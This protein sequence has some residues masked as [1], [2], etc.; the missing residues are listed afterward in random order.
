MPLKTIDTHVHVWDLSKADYPWL[1]GDTSLLNQTWEI[2]ALETERVAAGVTEGILVQAAGN[3]E[4]TDHMLHVA[5]NTSW[6]SGVVAWLPLLDPDAV[7]RQLEEKHLSNPYFCGVRHQ[8][9][10]EPNSEWLLQDKVIESLKILA[11][12]S[13]PFDIV[14]VKTA[15]IK[16][17]LE[18]VNRIPALNMVFDHLSQPPISSQQRFGEWGELM[19]TAAKHKA[20]SAKISGL[21]TASGHFEGRTRKEIQPYIE[22]AI[23]HFGVERCFCGGDWP[24]SL[25]AGEYSSIWKI[26]REVL[27]EILSTEEQEQVLYHSAKKFYTIKTPV[28]AGNT[29]K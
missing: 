18:V 28:K 22:F 17:A 10:D 21:G 5:A 4:D 8:I 6:I 27:E 23:K 19:R 25:L 7:Q 9:H 13:I 2:G 26:Y 3:E 14:A 11:G 24:V 12:Y 1:K 20:F 16:T 29:W 15:H